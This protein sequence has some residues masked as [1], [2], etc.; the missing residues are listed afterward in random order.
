MKFLNK[1]NDEGK[2]II[3]VTHNPELAREHAKIIYLIKD[4]K[5][6]SVK[7]N[8]RGKWTSVSAEKCWNVITTKRLQTLNL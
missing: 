8:I 6:E 3:I 1:L 4:G 2:T 5:L 7:K